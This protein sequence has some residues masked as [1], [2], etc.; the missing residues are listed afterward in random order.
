MEMN[1]KDQGLAAVLHADTPDSERAEALQ[2]YGQFVGDWDAAITSH[3]EHGAE[4]HSEGEIRFGWVLEGRAIQDVWMIPRL[5]DRKGARQFPIAGNWYGTTLRVFDPTLDAWRIYWIDPA[6]NSFRQQIGRARGPDIVQEGTTES[7]GLSRWSF[8][9]ITN[10]SFH[11]L[12]EAKPA[13][14]SDW[15]LLVEVEAQRRK[16]S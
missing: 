1:G 12:G 6:T 15:R 5:S 7:G 9:A 13:G 2:L 16:S 3:G 10:R 8:T 4:H 11:W 14:S